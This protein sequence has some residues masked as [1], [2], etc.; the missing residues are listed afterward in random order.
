MG[1]VR[2]RT[3][4]LSRTR[5]ASGNDAC[6]S[7]SLVPVPAGLTVSASGEVGQN[8][9]AT[10]TDTTI[11]KTHYHTTPPNRSNGDPEETRKRSTRQVVPSGQR[12]GIPRQSC[13]QADTAQ[14]EIQLPGEFESSHR[15]VRGARVMDAG[16]LRSVSSWLAH[17]GL[18]SGTYQSDP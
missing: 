4:I 15:P 8:Y 2:W 10:P 7:G 11:P 17:R 3:F 14:Q 1:R 18:R 9:F 13:F 16:C 6:G 12:E 5:R